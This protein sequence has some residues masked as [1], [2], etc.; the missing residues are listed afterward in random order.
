MVDEHDSISAP[1]PGAAAMQPGWHALPRLALVWRFAH[2][3]WS[4]AQLAA[5]AR[6]WVAALTGRR[7]RAVWASVAFIAMEGAGLAVGRGNCPV[8]RWQA[9]WGDPVPFFELILPPRAAKAAIP[10]LAATSTAGIAALVVRGVSPPLCGGCQPAL[11]VPNWRSP[12]SPRPGMMYPLSLS[13]RSRA[14]Q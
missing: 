9:A 3:A 4:I 11:P 10:V 5:L 13:W 7:G 6:I 2:A 12:A 1:E 14:A 8:G